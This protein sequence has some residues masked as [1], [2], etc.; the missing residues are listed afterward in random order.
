MSLIGKLWRRR[1]FLISLPATIRFNFKHLPFKKAIKLP[2]FLC[3]AKCS[4]KGQYIFPEN[5]STGMIKLGFPMVSVFPA[6]GIV[7]ENKGVIKFEGETA[8]G[9]GAGISVGKNGFLTFGDKFCN[10]TGAKIICYHKILFK[11]KVRVGWE[12]LICDTDFHTMKS[13]DGNKYTKGYGEIEIGSEVWVGSYCK[14][15]KNTSVPSR[16]TIASSTVLNKKIECEPYSLIYPGGGVK[17]KTTGYYRDL[18]D[19]TINYPPLT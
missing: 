11:E 7:L 6:K 4:G 12:T 9:G 17:V 1:D 13:S 10:Q 14:L 2:V 3:R 19:D 8:I 15:F 5:L 16:C 18:E